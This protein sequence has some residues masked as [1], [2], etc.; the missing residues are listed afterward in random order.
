MKPNEDLPP[1]EIEKKSTPALLIRQLVK[2][3]AT[4]FPIRIFILHLRRS[5]LMLSL[6]IG[7]ALAVSGIAFNDYGVH[8]L[9]MLPEY[10]GETSFAA[11]FITGLGLGLFTMSFHISSYIFYSYRYRFLAT[12]DRPIYRFSINNSLV[13]L[14]CIFYFAVKIYRFQKPIYD[15]GDQMIHLAGLFIGIFTMI[16][17]VFTYFFTF[18]RNQNVYEEKHVTSLNALLQ[19]IYSRKKDINPL[20]TADHSVHTY[21]RNFYR[22]RI[23]RPADHYE[24][25]KLLNALEQHHL[26][27][28]YFF[29]ALIALVIG[30]GYFEEKP[31]AQIPAASTTLILLSVFVMI[32]G[33]FFSRFKGWTPTAAIVFIF[34]L[35]YFSAYPPL[36]KPNMVTGLD[37]DME[38]VKFQ[39]DLLYALTT[40]SIVEEDTKHWTVILENWKKRQSSD[41]PKLVI[42][43]VS[44]GGLRSSLW[45]YEV[46]HQ[47]DSLLDGEVHHQTLLISGSSG[48]MIGASFFREYRYRKD[49]NSWEDLW[50]SFG[51][52]LR[53]YLGRDVLNPT[54]FNLLVNDLFFRFRSFEYAEKKYLKDRGTAF[55]R[56]LNKNTLGI[57]DRNL[58]EY[59]L[60]E[61][62]GEMPTMIFTPVMIQDGRRMLISAQPLS[63]LTFSKHRLSPLESKLFDGVEYARLFQNHGAFETSFLT[64]NR[65]SASF[66]YITPLVNLPSN[67]EIELIDAGVRDNDGFEISMRMVFQFREW[68][69]ENTSGVVIIRIKADRPDDEPMEMQPLNKQRLSDLIRPIQGVINSFSNLQTFNKAIIHQF[70]EEALDIPVEVITFP[71]FRPGEPEELALSWRLTKLER[72]A[73]QAAFMRPENNS[74]AQKV[75][76]AIR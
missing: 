29:L 53:E 35:N 64:I 33:A 9:F 58:G 57:M 14:I 50:P 54:I 40:D 13:P 63:F 16:A 17:L 43:N 73:I 27:A 48:G 41:K 59:R 44:G 26:R 10:L 4:F 31:W 5:P 45:T 28:A 23:T 69:R 39:R 1:N 34:L 42:A 12:L 6:W 24:Y 49:Q 76:Q 65:I 20:S 32:S 51:G 66:P 30:L 21:L 67:P 8:L 3:I 55:D 72:E 61:A 22:L 75:K 11:F 47:L 37:Y 18:N 7:F 52:E 36:Y 25:G 60:P 19:K 68:I 71:L 46:M 74:A 56:T 62:L 70:A 38:P 2:F 15:I